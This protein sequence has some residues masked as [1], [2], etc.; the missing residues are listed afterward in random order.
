VNAYAGITIPTTDNGAF[1]I[2]TTDTGED[3]LLQIVD[4]DKK[5]ANFKRVFFKILGTGLTPTGSYMQHDTA[6]AYST[7]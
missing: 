1:T 3:L 4:I 5:D 2:N 7:Q 6:Q